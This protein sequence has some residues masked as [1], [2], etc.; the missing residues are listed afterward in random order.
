MRW[1]GLI[2]LVLTLGFLALGSV[3]F[4]DK[5]IESGIEKAGQSIT[6]AKVEIDGF[7]LNLF[8][9][10]VQWDRLQ[11]ADARST[12]RNL[13]ETGRAAFRMSFPALLR[14]RVVIHEMT[15]ADV[16]SGS[17][18]KTDGALPQKEPKPTSGQPD[19]LDKVKAK[20]K[21]EI[22]TMPVVRFDLGKLKRSFNA[23]S[24]VAIAGLRLPGRLD[25]VRLDAAAAAADWDAFFKTFHP[26][27]D[28]VK[29]RDEIKNV[30]P[31][32]IKTVPELLST[33]NTVQ[34]SWK[35]VK[36]ISDTV[37]SRNQKFKQDYSRLSSYTGQ[38][39]T[40][41][42]DDYRGVLAKAQ[43]PDLSVQ[44]V[45]K[46]VFGPHLASQA[47]TWIDR[48]QSLKKILPKKSDKPEKKKK[49]KRT[50]M[51]GQDIAFA[52]RH[53]WPTFT[54]EKLS[55]SGQTGPTDSSA[56][57]RLRGEV[58]DISSQ[59][60]ITGRPVVVSLSG[61]KTDGRSVDVLAVLDHRTELASDSF[62][63]KFANV[64]LNHIAV[65]KSAYLP[66]QIRKGSADFNCSAMVLENAVSVKFSSLARG[67]AFD[68]DSTAVT[69][70][71]VRILRDVISRL[72]EITLN[73]GMK[74][75]GEDIHI[76]LDS[77]LDDK[78]GGELKRVGSQALTDAQNKITARLKNIENEKRAELAKVL[79]EKQKEFEQKLASCVK[80]SGEQKAL[81]QEKL[82]LVQD[83]IDKR[84]NKEQ[85]QLGKKARDLLDG[86]LK[87]K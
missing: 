82:K 22:E 33:L 35:T 62:T 73:A 50:R 39:K 5:W 49:E 42:Q 41:V 44:Q 9:L 34:A 14:R 70:T 1:K 3:L 43:L 55:L 83:E 47:E 31:K 29:V 24:L 75:A 2:P 18:R 25:S 54:V 15:V 86:V 4:M 87:K 60:W 77:N 64:S 51:R 27:D 23:D 11:A 20:I 67:L 57:F 32:Q 58:T 52:D 16:R 7:H 59:P 30:D 53:G 56:G 6:G 12:M 72:D 84:T 68:F 76:R 61:N 37:S 19:F 65:E 40:W 74:G 69:D 36:A 28:L 66:S 10:T 21:S 85:D 46:M 71:F 81:V 78:V 13:V 63:V 38:L 48:Y 26:D 79:E 17:P 45:G 8:K 80:L